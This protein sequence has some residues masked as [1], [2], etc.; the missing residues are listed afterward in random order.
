MGLRPLGAALRATRA[1]ATRAVGASFSHRPG[2]HVIGWSAHL[3]P[4]ATFP[5]MQAR[6][7]CASRRCTFCRRPL[8][9]HPTAPVTGCARPKPARRASPKQPDAEPSLFLFGFYEAAVRDLTDSATSGRS[10]CAL[11][12]GRN[13]ATEDSFLATNLG[14]S[15]ARP[16]HYRS[17]A[18]CA[19]S[20][21]RRA[22]ER[23]VSGDESASVFGLTGPEGALHPAGKLPFGSA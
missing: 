14:R 15:S 13:E 6:L 22:A 16:G 20:W 4:G 21:P 12:L 8:C 23:Q 10:P 18:P 1:T 9:G 2:H 11:K 7:A 3:R 17:A 5:S 19:R